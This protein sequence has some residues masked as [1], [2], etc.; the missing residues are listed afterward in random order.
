MIDNNIYRKKICPTCNGIGKYTTSSNE[1]QNDCGYYE[2]V[3]RINSCNDC[4]GS[5]EVFEQIT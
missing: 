5:G 2:W 1:F 4:N 3:D